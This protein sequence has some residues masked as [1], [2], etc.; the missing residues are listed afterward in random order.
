MKDTEGRLLYAK[1]IIEDEPDEALRICS[2]VLNESFDTQAGQMA[3][4]MTG[5]I[6]LQ[7]ERY[8]LAYQ[9]YQRC[10]QLRPDMSEI[11]SNMG[12]CLEDHDKHKA[13]KLFDKAIKLSNQ[14]AKGYAN[15][16]LMQLQ[17]GNPKGCIKSCERALNID[18]TLRSA[19]HN[20]GLAR[21][22]MRDWDGWE[23]YFDTIGVK[24]REKRDYGKPEWN[25]ED[26][27]VLVYGEQGVGDEIMFA[28]CLPDVMKTNNVVFDSDSRL[29]GLFRRSFDCE[30]YGDRFKTESRA[31]D[32]EF[33]YQ[34]AIGQLPYFYR[35]SEDSFPGTP[36]LTPDPERCIQWRA[37]FDTFPGKKIGIAWRG[38]LRNTGEKARSLELDDMEPILR[39]ENTYISLEYKEVH[40]LA[41]EKYN[42]KSY[43]RATAKGGDIDDLA[44]LVNELDMIVTSCTTVVYIAGA[45]GIPCHVLVP[46][47]PGYRYHT[48]GRFPWYT[49][50]TLHRKNRGQSWK[51]LVKQSKGSIYEDND[52]VRSCGDG[53]ISRPVQLDNEA[54]IGTC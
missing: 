1:S 34:C 26:G 35:R 30:V 53:C 49:S 19:I 9:I 21:L 12:M 25:G 8:G 46:D 7:A 23:D 11:W 52:R 45:L 33:D 18:S 50:V 14:N 43:P 39:D 38:G 48:E 22:M 13:I 31:A 17:T 27:T 5:Y 3:L 32:Q 47:T 29:E 10:A 37:L 54:C 4:F 15:K 16:G 6:F 24:H 41:L 20:R 36:Y 40:P 2:N 51:S 28:S 44:A 42:I